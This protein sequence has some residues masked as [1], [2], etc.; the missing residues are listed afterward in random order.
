MSA[1]LLSFIGLLASHLDLVNL[2]IQAVE[3]GGL[4]E[5]QVMGLI[6][7]AMVEAS[8]AAEKARLGLPVI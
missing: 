3:N 7:N 5:D 4:S 6:K 1:E 8:D 2:V